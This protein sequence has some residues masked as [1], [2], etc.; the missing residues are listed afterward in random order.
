MFSDRIRKPA[1]RLAE[2]RDDLGASHGQEFSR[3]HIER[4][5]FPAPRMD[6]QLQCGKRFGAR[7]FGHSRFVAVGT[8]LPANNVRRRDLRNC[9]EYLYFFIANGFAVIPNR[10]FHCQVRNQLEKVILDDIPDSASAFVETSP[11]LNTEIFRHRNLYALD[12]VP[13][14]ER[15]HEGIRETE[16]QHVV[17]WL[18]P[19]IMINP[20]NG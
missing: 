1:S 5:I 8:E 9:L 13:I 6:V 18:L 20:E 7:V 4:N 10:R 2:T 16:D 19:E 3:P 11:A 12:I 14:P 15:F 17:N